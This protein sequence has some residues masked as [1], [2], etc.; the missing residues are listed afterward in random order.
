MVK[1]LLFILLFFIWP[2][3][4]IANPISDNKIKLKDLLLNITEKERSIKQKKAERNHLIEKLKKQEK[5]ISA[6]AQALYEI[7][8]KLSQ[9]E[10]ELTKLNKNISCLQQQKQIH[11]LLLAKQLDAVF[12][13]GKQK[14]IKLLFKGEQEQREERILA[15]YSY[16]NAAREQT[17][18]KLQQTTSLL[19]E[20]K[21]QKQQKQLKK[22]KNLAKQDQK[23]KT[24][25][26]AQD[27][28]KKTLLSLESTL[29]ADQKSLATMKRNK[30]LLRSKIARAERESK[31]RVEREVKEA[32]RI[33][34]KESQAYQ[35]G[36]T[37]IPTEDELALMERTGG[38]GHPVG[39]I[40]WP[41]H[42][43]ILHHYGESISDELLWNGMVINSSEGTEVKA[44]SAGR[45]LLAD[46]LRGYGLV[47]V[48]DHG[49]G[50]MSL[51]GY[52]QSAL[53]NVGQQVRSG[54][55]VALVG[56][57]GGQQCFS[58]YFEIRR[59][60]KTVNPQLWLRR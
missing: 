49:Q 55:S 21:K 26:S 15:Y 28:R 30:I 50:D 14:R 57:S 23:K 1:L 31:V 7:R 29:K 11:E 3:I 12:R 24:L 10:K 34:E 27:A 44:I 13:L 33:R 37:Y 16:L 45:V 42:G 59:Q 60:G 25:D 38:L 58:L 35:K 22:K 41:V 5:N 32:A 56:S 8:E 52:N 40:L 19:D 20:Q 4:T 46:W 43:Q 51:Y 53:V 48:I 9:L 39:Q 6:A 2:L 47:V 54:Q 36:T 17:I 18:I